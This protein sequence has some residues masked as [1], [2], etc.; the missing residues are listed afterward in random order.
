MALSD[1]PSW[2]VVGQE[3]GLTALQTEPRKRVRAWGEGTLLSQ[4][5]C[6][7]QTARPRP[8]R[9]WHADC[10]L[11][12]ASGPWVPVV[13]A[14][15]AVCP[16][17]LQDPAPRRCLMHV[18]L[19]NWLHVKIEHRLHRREEAPVFETWPSVCAGAGVSV[20]RRKETIEGCGVE[21]GAT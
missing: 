9:G 5:V 16:S 17:V 7:E 14:R 20:E 13:L 6:Q 19:V 8:I 18:F 3:G 4:Q 11:V 21:A 1:E 12:S 2:E 10:P 15:I